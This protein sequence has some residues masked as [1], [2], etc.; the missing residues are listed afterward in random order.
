MCPLTLP[1]D[2]PPGHATKEDQQAKDRTDDDQY[3]PEPAFDRPREARP[4]LWALDQVGSSMSGRFG[5]LT[6]ARSTDYA[7]HE[8][9]LQIVTLDIS[10]QR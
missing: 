8:T 2:K 6:A 10:A 3:A 9:A 7:S 4:A 5:D 1:V